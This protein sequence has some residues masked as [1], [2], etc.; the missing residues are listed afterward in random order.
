MFDG[1]EY[2]KA[3]VAA[4]QFRY[5]SDYIGQLCRGKKIDARLVGRTWFVNLDSI[6]DHKRSRHKQKSAVEGSSIANVTGEKAI[7]IRTSRKQE[8]MPRVK[9][10]TLKQTRAQVGGHSERHLKVAYEPDDENLI[11]TIHKKQEMQPKTITI[12]HVD[13]KRLPIMAKKDEVN[14]HAGDL[15]EV[16]LSGTLE[17]TSYTAIEDEEK[18]KPVETK[19]KEEV[20]NVRDSFINKV[21]SAKQK[22]DIALKKEPEQSQK[23]MQEESLVSKKSTTNETALS[24]A[25]QCVVIEAAP[26][27]IVDGVPDIVN[28][29][30]TSPM[31]TPRSV[32]PVSVEKVSL[33]MLIS[34]LIATLL[35][36]ISVLLIMLASASVVVTQTTYESHLVFQVSNLLELLQY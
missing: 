26:V 8:V 24:D 13:A 34:P 30:K 17:V 31:F 32:A 25:E 14:F 35:A 23:R 5:T 6:K 27:L 9:T 16:S 33:F 20:N 36:V 7:V 21:M 22:K 4:K 18:D 11:P 1:V 3:S 29:S 28:E 12:E 10:V 15:P 19:T 2:V